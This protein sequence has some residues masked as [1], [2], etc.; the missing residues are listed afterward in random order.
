MQLLSIFG[1]LALILSTVGIYSVLAYSV[2]RGMKDIGLRIAFGATRGD[3]MQFVVTQAIKPT[4]IG[5][6]LGLAAAYSLSRLMTSMVYGVSARDTATF[7]AV[8]ALLVVV[9]LLASLIPAL[10][11]T[12]INPLTVIRD[13]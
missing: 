1:L 2:K 11:A 10:R 5:I 8:T 3:V 4:A 7:I 9:A 13:E 12:H 6:A